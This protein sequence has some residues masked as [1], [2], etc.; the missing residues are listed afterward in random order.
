MIMEKE[1]KFYDF[2]LRKEQAANELKLDA[3]NMIYDVYKN[4]DMSAEAKNTTMSCLIVAAVQAIDRIEA[5]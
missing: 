5:I 2:D 4:K 1:R 3:M